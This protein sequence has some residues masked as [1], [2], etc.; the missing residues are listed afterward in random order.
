MCYKV[1]VKAEGRYTVIKLKV[2]DINL[3]FGASCGGKPVAHELSG[4]LRAEA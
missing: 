2:N 4:P 1:K 3:Q